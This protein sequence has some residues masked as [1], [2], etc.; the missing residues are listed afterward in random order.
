MT[1]LAKKYQRAPGENGLIIIQ[2][3]STK[4]RLEFLDGNA[5]FISEF[6]EPSRRVETRL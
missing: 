1:G 6:T 5:K 3:K 4:C 2:D